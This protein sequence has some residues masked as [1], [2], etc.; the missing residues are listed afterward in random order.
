MELKGNFQRLINSLN[1]RKSQS[2][3]LRLNVSLSVS[4]SVSQ[5]VSQSVSP[6]SYRCLPAADDQILVYRLN[7]T[8]C[9]GVPSQTRLRVCSK[10][11]I[12]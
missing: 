2:H 11:T 1:M 12:N 8:V 4:H 10:T 5:S 3:K 9:L 6:S 7:N